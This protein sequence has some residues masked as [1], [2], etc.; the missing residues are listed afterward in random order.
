MESIQRP[1]SA[2][3]ELAKLTEITENPLQ[4][5]RSWGTNYQVASTTVL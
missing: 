3:I 4:K 2:G 5:G 1:I